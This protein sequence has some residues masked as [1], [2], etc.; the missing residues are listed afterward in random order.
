MSDRGPDSHAEPAAPFDG[1]GPDEVLDALA[2][3]GL[4]PDGTLLALNSY[5]NRVYRTGLE[6]GAPRVLKFY[7]PG[8][9]ADEAIEE[10]HAFTAEL[11]A[12]EIPVVA[13]E[14][15]AG[16]TLHHHAGFRY[17]V[18]PL[19]GGHWPDLDA[20][21]DR[22]RVGRLI[23]RL[24][25]VAAR[26]IFAHRPQLDVNATGE[27]ARNLLLEGGF[28][29]PGLEDAW[30]AVSADLLDLCHER[31][32]AVS[33]RLQRTHG[34]LHRSNL[35][36]REDVLHVV[37]LDDCM[38]APAVQ[39]LWMFLDGGA[40]EQPG[41]LEALLEGYG[42]FASLDPSELAL[43]EPLRALRMIHYS[44]WLAA[45]W[46]DPAF[47]RAFPWFAEPRYWEEQVLALKEQLARVQQCG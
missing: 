27:T 41:Q 11:A 24:H 6:A 19:R 32:E 44:A 43:I 36:A 33:P 18:F 10:E 25:Q 22:I 9:W 31:W 8:R 35:L 40:D 45:R 13:P 28:I 37:D 16:R 21:E 14:A 2:V 23:G 7:R 3:L 17:A 29:A 20:R 1:L 39:D 30:E 47:P 5:E 42:T 15:H 38:T 34:D 12:A 26:G 46:H 4:E